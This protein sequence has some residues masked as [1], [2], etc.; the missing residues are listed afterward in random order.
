MESGAH[1]WDAAP[2]SNPGQ[3]AHFSRGEKEVTSRIMKKGSP[4][5][6]L[7]DCWLDAISWLGREFKG[8]WKYNN[9]NVGFTF[10]II[11][12]L[13]EIE[14]AD[15]I[16]FAAKHDLDTMYFH[17]AIKQPDASQ[18]VEAIV[19]KINGH[20]ERGHWQLIPVEEVPKG[21]QI[22]NAA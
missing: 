1:V 2:G 11:E 20:I 18:F 14:M 16:A 15:L 12:N 5:P 17:Q 6:K 8:A 10:M 22:L 3:S 19:K 9:S 7:P 4:T 21:T 13:I